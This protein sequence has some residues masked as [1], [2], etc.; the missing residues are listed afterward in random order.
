MFG[1]RLFGDGLTTGKQ[2]PPMQVAR[3]Q[4]KRQ[5]GSYAPRGGI[6]CNLTAAARPGHKS[7]GRKL[8]W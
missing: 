5:R 2:A 3:P 7:E 8:R 6:I 1:G 4:N